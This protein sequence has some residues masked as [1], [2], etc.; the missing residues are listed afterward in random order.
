MLKLS[1]R[2]FIY[3][4][5]GVAAAAGIGYMTKNYWLPDREQIAT[6]SES[7]TTTPIEKVNNP[8]YADFNL[9]NPRYIKPCVGQEV[10]FENLSDD[11][12]KDP[13][14]FEWYVNYELK[15]D[16]ED[17]TTKFSEEGKHNIN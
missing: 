15:G 5:A 3:V 12:D 8:P 13:L 11:I 16:S 1:R 7:F 10:L 2:K 4:G 17:F 14:T 6:P 9:K